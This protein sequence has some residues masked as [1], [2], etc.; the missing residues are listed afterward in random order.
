MSLCHPTDSSVPLN[1]LDELFL[2]LDDG[3]EPWNVHFEVRCRGRLEADRLAES[4]SAAALRHPLARARLGEW[5][6]SDRGYRWEIAD[7]LVEVPLEVVT[8]A[9]GAELAAARERVLSQS[10]PLD[11]APPFMMLLA[12]GPDG[13][14]VVLNLHHAAG[15]GI[16][17][18]RLM[19]SIL[20]AYAGADDPAPSLDPLAVR[21]VSALAGAT[22]LGDRLVRVQALAQHAARQWMGAARV[23]VDGGGDRPG[24]G[25]EVLALSSAETAAVRGRRTGDTT[26]NDVLLAALA[27]AVHRWNA[28][29]G[30]AARR[31]TLSMP[32]NLRPPEWRF[33]V[34]GNFASYVTVSGSMADDLPCALEC[35]GRQTRAIKRDGLAGL[36]VDLLAGYSML[37]IA[38]K[39]RLPDLIALTG[40]IVV[41]TASLSNL[42]TLADMGDDVE[43]VWFSPPGR[44][45]L[46]AALGVATYDDRLHL[47]LRYRHAQFDE[48][49]AGAFLRLFH[50][51]LLDEMRALPAR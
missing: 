14:S 35:V 7:A 27:V 48:P 33:E 51:V 46:G 34:V 15:D 45:P 50:D 21:D 11:A 30:S 5:R 49:A 29:H 38:S 22:S 23:A 9:D 32:V 42:G 25:V 16:A 41:D 36:V 1:R 19:L 12:H 6:H 18:A 2:M 39:R 20:R 8:C 31:V 26:V 47:A 40:D 17:A 10:P 28:G 13:D 43:A 37:T 44:M 4:I 24:Y 3:E